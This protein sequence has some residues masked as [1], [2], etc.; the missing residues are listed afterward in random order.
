MAPCIISAKHRTTIVKLHF[1]EHLKCVEFQEVF[2]WY[3]MSVLKSEKFKGQWKRYEIFIEWKKI[4]LNSITISEFE[5]DFILKY[6]K[7]CKLMF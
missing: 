2:K 5:N 7:I 3:S 4:P 1:T 6:H